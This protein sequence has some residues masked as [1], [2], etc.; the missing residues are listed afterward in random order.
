MRQFFREM[1]MD[2]V[3]MVPS[4]SKVDELSVP[5]TTEAEHTIDGMETGPVISVLYTPRCR[6][7]LRLFDVW[8]PLSMSLERIGLECFGGRHRVVIVAHIFGAEG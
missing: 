6:Q 1:W 7:C 5:D 4:S 8:V 2:V 3:G